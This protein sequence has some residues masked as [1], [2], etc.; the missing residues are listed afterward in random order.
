[1]VY[2]GGNFLQSLWDVA[3]CGVNIVDVL[4]QA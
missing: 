2:K 3:N 1:M 4:M